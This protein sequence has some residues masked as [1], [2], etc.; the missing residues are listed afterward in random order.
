[1]LL[2]NN[3][4]LLEWQRSFL[5]CGRPGKVTDLMMTH[6]QD[7]RSSEQPMFDYTAESSIQK[8][9]RKSKDNPLMVI[10]LTGCFF[11]ATYGIY[12]FRHRGKLSA[13]NY[14]MQ[15]RVMA[16]GTVIGCLT[17]GIMKSIY[18]KVASKKSE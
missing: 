6:S 10:G 4:L 3:V 18:D 17:L 16:Q 9:A 15:L 13:S 2:C 11:V 7:E 14:L 1:M 12:K 5:N 8:L